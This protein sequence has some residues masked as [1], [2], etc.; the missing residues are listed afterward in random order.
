MDLPDFSTMAVDSS[1]EFSYNN[2]DYR[3]ECFSQCKDC[4]DLDSCMAH[5][6]TVLLVL[7]PGFYQTKQFCSTPEEVTK[8]FIEGD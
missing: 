7:A 8:Y 2:K 4:C 1:I 3:V 6:F 5:S